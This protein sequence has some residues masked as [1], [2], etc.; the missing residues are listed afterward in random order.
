MPSSSKKMPGGLGNW[1][2][3]STS[4][5]SLP[6]RVGAMLSSSTCM[7]RIARSIARQQ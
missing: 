2:V 7:N 4:T 5:A 1:R 3:M 6:S